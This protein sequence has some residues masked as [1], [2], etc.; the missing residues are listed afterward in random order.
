[1]MMMPSRRLLMAVALWA[2]LALLMA[3]SPLLG[4]TLPGLLRWLWL[5]TGTLLG[6]LALLDLGLAWR[7]PAPEGERQLPA[8][9]AAGL[10][11]TVRVRLHSATLPAGSLL[12]DQHPGDDAQ[13]GL[14]VMVSPV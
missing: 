1:S 6:A 9:F 8:A 11:G 2:G 10:P 5:S 12:A 3:F 4:S 14:P 13:T 7:R